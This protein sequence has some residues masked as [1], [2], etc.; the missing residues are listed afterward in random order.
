[1]DHITDVYSVSSHVNDDVADYINFWK[2]NGYW[3]FD[4]PDIIRAVAIENSIS[5]ERTS[6]F[7][8]EVY[9]MQFDGES[10]KAYKPEESFATNVLLPSAKTLEGFDVVTGNAPGCSPLSCNGLAHELR[11]NVHCLF[12]SFDDA[13][14]NLTQG[15]FNNSE[16]GPYGI[17]AVYSAPWP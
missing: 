15:K 16:P 13:Y 2:H 4:S 12:D 9:E 10:W 7:F 14:M 3:L 8:Y 6:L 1:M 17:F 5:L 11:T